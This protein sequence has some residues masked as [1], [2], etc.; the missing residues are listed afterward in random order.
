MDTKTTAVHSAALI[1]LRIYFCRRFRVD[2]VLAVGRKIER[3]KERGRERGREKEKE[4][5]RERER[6]NESE[7]NVMKSRQYDNDYDLMTMAKM[8]NWFLLLPMKN[9]R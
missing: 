8:K 7:R 1:W 5:K 2:I 3:E 6:E 4:R 9:V